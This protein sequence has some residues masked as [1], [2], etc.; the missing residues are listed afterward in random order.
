MLRRLLRPLLFLLVI[1][2]PPAN[3]QPQLSQ[4]V[5]VLTTDGLGMG[6]MPLDG[7][8]Q[9]H[10]GDESSWASPDLDD[11]TGRNGWE[12]IT[13]D[14][15]W[16]AQ[17]HSGYTGIAWYRRHI[18]VR[19][20]PGAS[21]EVA[22][23]IP[24]V[25][26]A[27]EVYWNGALVGHFGKLPPDPVWYLNPPPQTMGL[28]KARSGVLA[29]R[30]WK[31]PRTSFDTVMEGGFSQ[32]PSIGSQEAIG[33]L[34]AT[35]GLRWSTANGSM[36]ALDGLYL[37]V[38]LIAL[39]VWRRDR[40]QMLLFWM[41]AC[42]LSTETVDL[43]TYY[44][45]KI[46]FVASFVMTQP[47]IGVSAVAIW[48]VLALLLRLDES[49][50]IMRILRILAIFAIA[51]NVLDALATYL[52]VAG[53]GSVTAWAQGADR[54]LSGI[55]NV[56]QLL[57][58]TLILCAVLRRKQLA[59]ERWVVAFFALLECLLA[60]FES[61]FFQGSRFE[62]VQWLADLLLRPL[63]AIH[64][65]VVDP[66]QFIDAL[67]FLAIVFAVYRYWEEDR[68]RQIAMEQEFKSARELQRV[69]I[70]EE[71][72]MAPGYTLTSSYKPAS[73]VGGDFFQVIPLNDCATLIVLG[74]VSG[75]G[76]KAAMAVS[77]IVGAT[78]MAVEITSSPAGILSAL[79]RRL[80]GRLK[81]GF[82]TCVAMRL[83][84]DGGCKIASAG[85]PAPFLNG[86]EITLPGA[87]PL[88]LTPNA[89]YEEET[90]SLNPGDHFALYT[91][92]LLEARNPQGELY[93][94]ERMKTLF[95]AG[96]TAEQAAEAAVQFG[97]D[98]DITVLTINRPLDLNPALP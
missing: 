72:P 73:E 28:G 26:D 9:F 94:F 35:D 91:D 82:A 46:P 44:Q 98:D 70:P 10:L 58:V 86:D 41:A 33:G 84:I 3:A 42:N 25:S 38:G 71:R 2:G 52:I 43:F 12:Q 39:F 48:Y 65:A 92:G 14:M 54:V 68:R 96:P 90:L 24:V 17:S 40:R 34:K 85:H 19:L 59:V 51:D 30:V 31:A 50:I 22:L 20:A 11:S 57:P 16:G 67:L 66:P 79:N 77:L 74:D 60:A 27:Y 62:P 81:G 15:P 87:L 45:L 76:L 37:L 83:E 49:K 64:G 8:W 55:F 89:E 47:L 21:P 56:E 23:Y 7:P 53:S 1:P 88:G 13:A 5:P 32:A 29:V 78:R 95:A 75:K 6:T 69:L 63:F 18:R 97:Q 80:H 4:A 36:F 61:F 93:S